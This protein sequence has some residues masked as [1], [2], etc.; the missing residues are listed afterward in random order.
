MNLDTIKELLS[1]LPQCQRVS[2][3]GCSNGSYLSVAANLWNAECKGFDINKDNINQYIG[4]DHSFHIL[5]FNKEIPIWECDL[6]ICLD[7]ITYLKDNIGKMVVKGLCESAPM[8]L[9]SSLIPNIDNKFE[10][11]QW[12][13]YWQNE[14]AKY[15]FHAYDIKDMLSYNQNIPL[16]L[17]QSLILY[18]NKDLGKKV[19]YINLNLEHSLQ[20][21]G[22]TKLENYIN[23]THNDLNNFWLGYDYENNKQPAAAYSFYLRA[24]E[25]TSNKNLAYECLIRMSFC[26]RDVKERTESEYEKLLQAI[27]IVPDRPE[28]YYFL[29]CYFERQT[30]WIDIEKNSNIGLYFL[31]NRQKTL[32]DLFYKTYGLKFQKGLGYYWA[33]RITQAEKIMKELNRTPDLDNSLKV[34]VT[35]NIEFITRM[36]RVRKFW[37]WRHTPSISF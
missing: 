23:D 11:P 9:F 18:S 1:L 8:V 22:I 36:P 12:Q 20:N 29:C 14:F 21:P 25:R 6:A 30:Q 27:S 37:Q 19:P 15:G 34:P 35:N 5:D 33:G 10:N 32:T 24:A 3:W 17:Q 13:S 4:P 26:L 28:A 16:E 7:T 2:D 31:R